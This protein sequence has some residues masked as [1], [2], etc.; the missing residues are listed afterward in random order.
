MIARKLSAL[1][2]LVLACTCVALAQAV[3]VRLP[4]GIMRTSEITT[5]KVNSNTQSRTHVVDKDP[6]HGQTETSTYTETRDADGNLVSQV[7]KRSQVNGTSTR[8]DVQTRTYGVLGGSTVVTDSTTRYSSGGASIVS[9]EDDQL[10]PRGKLVRRDYTQT[11]SVVGQRDVVTHETDTDNFFRPLTSDGLYE[12]LRAAKKPRSSQLSIIMSYIEAIN[13]RLTLLNASYH[14]GNTT[15]L[16]A[17]KNDGV[18]DFGQKQA[19]SGDFFLQWSAVTPYYTEHA[20]ALGLVVSA[21]KVRALTPA[22]MA[23]YATGMQS[24]RT[25]EATVVAAFAADLKS[26]VEYAHLQDQ[27]NDAWVPYLRLENDPNATAEATRAAQQ[28]YYDALGRVN[29]WHPTN[30]YG[31]AGRYRVFSGVAPNGTGSSPL[32]PI[33]PPMTSMPQLKPL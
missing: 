21:L 11:R 10:D 25:G 22:E 15:L 18:K 1:V 19:C 33:A 26:R 7:T 28:I 16:T 31:D 30:S 29:A 6:L 20:Y 5:T 4:S 14:S 2:L 24:W 13:A 8:D 12:T 9:H 23:Y 17:C 3:T 27:L 32:R